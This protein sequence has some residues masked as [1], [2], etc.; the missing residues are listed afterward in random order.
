MRIS[1]YPCHLGGYKPPQHPV[2]AAPL[3]LPPHNWRSD[4]FAF[5]AVRINCLPALSMSFHRRSRLVKGLLGR[6]AARASAPSLP[7]SLPLRFKLTKGHFGSTDFVPC[8]VPH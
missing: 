1:A 5:H 6:T 4:S 8:K 2:H 7:I 3:A